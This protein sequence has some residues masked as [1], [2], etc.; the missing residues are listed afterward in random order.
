MELRSLNITKKGGI[1]AF[2]FY[3]LFYVDTNFL[4]TNLYMHLFMHQYNN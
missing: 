2:F 1:D 4:F 3:S